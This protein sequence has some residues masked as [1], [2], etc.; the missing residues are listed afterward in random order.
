M[1]NIVLSIAALLVSQPG[2]ATQDGGIVQ[3]QLAEADQLVVGQASTTG[4]QGFGDLND[5]DDIDVTL[6][7]RAGR[8][9]FIVGVCD[10]D[11][12]DLD[13]IATG[14]AGSTLDSDLETD[15]VP[16]L[17]FVADGTGRVTLS[18]SMADCS[19]E[20]CGYGYRVYLAN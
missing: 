20:P 7:L 1:L 12:S 6:A 11:C 18:I 3:Q 13:L 4:I 16:L 19:D 5:G 10:S 8:E 17:S 14:G 9:Y 2:P 15:D